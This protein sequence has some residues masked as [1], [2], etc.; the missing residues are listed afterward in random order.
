MVPLINLG[1]EA[2][3]V[4]KGE[5]IAQGI[6]IEFLK[7]VDDKTPTIQRI[8]GFGSSDKTK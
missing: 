6:F 5:R 4:L 3:T 2:V 8:G 7:T 1:D